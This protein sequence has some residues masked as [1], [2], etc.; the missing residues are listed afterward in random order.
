MA[1]RVSELWQG[2]YQ[3]YGKESI[4]VMARRVSELWQ[5][6][7]RSYGKDRVRVMAR[8]GPSRQG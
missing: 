3:S 4:R 6:E 1:R 2:E 7:H 8:I 5:E